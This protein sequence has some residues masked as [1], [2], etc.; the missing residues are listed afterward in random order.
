MLR[1]LST[2]SI[3]S[4]IGFSRHEIDFF[5]PDQTKV[6]TTKPLFKVKKLSSKT[7]LVH[8]LPY[9]FIGEIS[10]KS[11]ETPDLMWDGLRRFLG[12]FR[13]MNP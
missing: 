2:K 5:L 9:K 10:S 12:Y 7:W 13:L 11:D 6:F 4:G 8:K 1:R 3:F